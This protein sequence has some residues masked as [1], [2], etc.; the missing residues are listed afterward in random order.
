MDEIINNIFNEIQEH[1]SV[2]VIAG[3]SDIK[4]D[5]IANICA[6]KLC[7]NNNYI[8]DIYHVQRTKTHT[9]EKIYERIVD[10]Y[11]KGK[12]SKTVAGF[13]KNCKNC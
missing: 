8:I 9:L 7:E 11:E 13:V 3:S 5:L 12:T 10:D 4:T 1:R 2:F 6:N